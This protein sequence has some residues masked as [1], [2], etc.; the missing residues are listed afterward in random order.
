MS[1]VRSSPFGTLPSG[2]V[3]EQLPALPMP[4]AVPQSRTAIL[5]QWPTPPLF[6]ASPAPLAGRGREC[7]LEFVDGRSMTGELVSIESDASSVNLRESGK[8]GLR[9]VALEEV[10]SIRLQVPLAFV[11]DRIALGEIGAGALNVADEKPFTVAFRDGNN[12]AGR[13]RGFLNGSHGL[14]LFLVED[15][16][17]L[18][19]SCFIPKRQIR[20]V[21]IGPLLGDALKDNGLVEPAALT[22]ALNQQARERDERLGEFL[23]E[24]SVVS[25]DQLTRA[26]QEQNRR[27]NVKLGELLVEAGLISSEDLEHALG[28]QAS[29]RQRRLGDI[30]ISMG[31]VSARNIQM[32]LSD[33][34]GIPHVNVREFAIEPSVLDLL[35]GTL[36]IRH[37]ALPLLRTKEGL[38]VAVENPLLFD[39]EQDLRF[40][41]GLAII[42]VIGNPDDIRA[43]LAREYLVGARSAGGAAGHGSSGRRDSQVRIEELASQLHTEAPKHGSGGAARQPEAS[44]TDSTLVRLVNKIIV[45]AHAQ[46][47]S[48]IHIETDHSRN[49]R[50]RFRKDGDLVNYLELQPAYRN[51]VV[52]RLKIMAGLDISERRLAQDG[53]IDFGRFGAVA[54]ELR[55]AIIP[56]SDNQEDVVMRLTGGVAPAPLDG[57]GFSGTDLAALK[58][59]VAR[60]YGLLLVCGP[61]GSG[62][63]TTLHSLLHHINTPDLK[64]WTAEDPI[65]IT[66]PGL[67]QV[68]V[69]PKIDWTFAAAM[70]SFLRADPDVIMV[71]E[72][73]DAETTKVGIEA[74]LTGHLV[75]STLHTNSAAESVTRLLNLGMDPFNFGDAL[76]GVLSQRLARKLCTH[77]KRSHLASEMELTEL[78]NEYCGGT[79]LDPAAVVK[80]WG[81]EFGR[82]LNLYTARG[83]HHCKHGYQGRLGVYELLMASPRVKELIFAR[84]TAPELVE[85]ARAG[86]MRLLKQDA[87]RKVLS[88]DID[89]ISARAVSN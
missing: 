63:T 58:T 84:A 89:L 8:E 48:D 39:F 72:M 85:A 49:T 15:D 65:E 11:P 19:V 17:R 14:F 68:Q 23:T 77:C 29:N 16:P 45:D 62:K 57:L 67:R 1:T 32:A 30:L 76:L 64:I 22:S 34:L 28:I 78:A 35:N 20:D 81:A 52:S 36:A 18:T 25:A 51:A 4:A 5:F 43:R 70:R 54:I 37:Q 79:D 69:N 55:I 21:Q 66:Q 80:E 47:A 6:Q 13:T 42:P 74:S 9:Q 2:P 86:G 88:G 83:C 3:T 41:S 33:K 44:V 12:M 38:V 61:T 50:I 26:L 75:L 71:G 27:P 46:G 56:T 59:L 24:R 87:L 40:A 10:R 82:R 31:V 53:K 7:T 60:S 73:R